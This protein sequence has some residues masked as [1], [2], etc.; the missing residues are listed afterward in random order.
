MVIV[1]VVDVLLVGDLDR[2]LTVLLEV[3][4]VSCTIGAPACTAVAASKTGSCSITSYSISSSTVCRLSISRSDRSDDV[5]DVAN[6]VVEKSA[7]LRSGTRRNDA[8]TVC[9]RGR[10]DGSERSMR[11]F[12]AQDGRME[13]RW[14]RDV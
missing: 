3:W 7:K 4:L 10:V 5:A 14:P 9:R 1:D 11:R 6:P 2:M 13:R 8:V 12:C